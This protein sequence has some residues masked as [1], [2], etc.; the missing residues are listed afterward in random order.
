M[1]GPDETR[2]LRVIVDRASYLAHEHVEVAI[3]DEDVW[4]DLSK[5]VGL[6]DDVRS[7]RDKNAQHRE[8]FRGEVNLLALSQEL[9]RL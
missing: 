9:P 3:D 2:R 1:H 4:P 6:R 8:C 7:P 5:Q